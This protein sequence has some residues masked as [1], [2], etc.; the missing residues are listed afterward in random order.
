MKFSLASVLDPYRYDHKIEF[1]LTLYYSTC[2]CT[3]DKDVILAKDT[4]VNIRELLQVVFSMQSVPRHY[5]DRM[6]AA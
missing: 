5:S 1:W 3:A 6:S 2:N 4:Y